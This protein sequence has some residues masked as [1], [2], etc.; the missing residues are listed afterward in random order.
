MSV[1]FHLSDTINRSACGRSN[2]N[3]TLAMTSVP[4][5]VTCQRCVRSERYKA[6]TASDQGQRAID[7]IAAALNEWAENEGLCEQYEE[8]VEIA[9]YEAETFGLT[10]PDAQVTRTWRITLDTWYVEAKSEDEALQ[11]IADDPSQY[12]RVEKD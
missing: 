6:L 12:L 8:A 10:W 1:T 4:G 7:K 5:G 2:A 3:R 9:R 11:K